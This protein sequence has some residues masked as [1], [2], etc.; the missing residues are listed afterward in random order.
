MLAGGASRRLGGVPKGL[1]VVGGT[2]II[3]RVAS[4]L[5]PVT[6]DLLLVANDPEG[7]RWLPGVAVLSDL[8]PGAGGMAGVEAALSLGCNA[9]VVAWDMPFVTQ[10]LLAALIEAAQRHDADVV[11]PESHSPYGFE[12]FCALYAARVRPSLSEFLTSGG[13]AA[14]DFLRQVPR[15]HR[16]PIADVERIGDARR[17]FFSVN[18]P[19]ELDRA[20]AMAGVSQ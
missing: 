2:R 3:D 19:E 13:G 7:S 6:D 17:M 12:P 9:L 16:L 8:H 18:T 10:P 4:V 15:V 1:E 11:L 5:R 20:R 14:R